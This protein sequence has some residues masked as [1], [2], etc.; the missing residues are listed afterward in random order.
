MQN[1][2][3]QSVV[4]RLQRYS[5]K[6]FSLYK[7]QITDITWDKPNKKALITLNNEIYTHQTIIVENIPYA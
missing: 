3:L 7:Y 5:A 4:N 6:Y 1:Q 2:V